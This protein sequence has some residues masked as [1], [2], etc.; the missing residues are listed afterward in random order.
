[1]KTR[2]HPSRQVP[3]C[4]VKL[5]RVEPGAYVTADGRIRVEN[6]NEGKRDACWVAERL[7][8][9]AIVARGGTLKAVRQKLSQSVEAPVP[10]G[11]VECGATMTYGNCA[12]CK[13]RTCPD[14]HK[15]SCPGVDPHAALLRV[16]AANGLRLHPSL[17]GN[18]IVDRTGGDMIT[19]SVWPGGG[20]QVRVRQNRGGKR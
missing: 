10:P 8:D 17:S 18:Y 1:M 15:W 7:S 2:H 14:C 9:R 11:C 12:H 3:A 6:R 20:Y 19:I 13:G 16:A 5:R 4:P